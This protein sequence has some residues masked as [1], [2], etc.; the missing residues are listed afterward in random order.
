MFGGVFGV[1]S[2]VALSLA[3]PLYIIYSLSCVLVV[4]VS[5][6]SCRHAM[7]EFKLRILF[8]ISVLFWC[9]PM[10][11]TFIETGVSLLRPSVRPMFVISARLR[12]VLESCPS[13]V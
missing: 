1:F 13:G 11:D 3:S 7:S 10:S 12:F 6:V 8:I 9:A 2:S 4:I 5:C